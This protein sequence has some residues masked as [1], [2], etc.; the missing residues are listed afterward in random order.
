MDNK[1]VWHIKPQGSTLERAIINTLNF[2]TDIIYDTI[3]KPTQEKTNNNTN[4]IAE[5]DRQV[6]SDNETILDMAFEISSM[7]IR[8]DEDALL[9][10]LKAAGCEERA[11]LD[12]QKALL[13][14]ELPYT[15]GGGIG[16][17]RICMY[18]LRKAHVGEVQSSVWKAEDE[19][20]AHKAGI[21][22]L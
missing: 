14:G 22:L 3:V 2:V 19:E 9:R 13:N 4:Q 6:T 8:V 10:Q 7:G 12:F 5:I 16:Q 15:V 1:S 11:E 20:K 18:F 17:S 21:Q